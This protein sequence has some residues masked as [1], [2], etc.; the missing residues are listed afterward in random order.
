MC[1]GGTGRTS[2]TSA[3]MWGGGTGRMSV[4]SFSMW[5]GDR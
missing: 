4:N 5:G 3:S 2:V 1:V